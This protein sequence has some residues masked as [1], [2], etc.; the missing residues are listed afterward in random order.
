M[1]C[2]VEYG[3]ERG[4]CERASG[5][6]RPCDGAG[7]GQLERNARL[8]DGAQHGSPISTRGCSGNRYN[9]GAR[10]AGQGRGSGRS[11]PFSRPGGP[12]E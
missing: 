3:E 7:K 10:G 6:Y 8:E 4:R 12:L 11:E 2:A 1:A 9:E 5:A